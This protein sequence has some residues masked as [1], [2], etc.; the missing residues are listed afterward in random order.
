MIVHWSFVKVSHRFSH[1]PKLLFASLTF[2]YDESS[3]LVTAKFRWTYRLTD[4]INQEVL[5]SF[6]EEYTFTNSALQE[7]TPIALENNSK[8]ILY[9]F[10]KQFAVYTEKDSVMI[11]PTSFYEAEINYVLI[12][13]EIQGGK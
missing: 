4:T 8:A 13:E 12:S 1:Q 5:F 3:S 7:A 11:Q 10:Q 9:H 6:I 2:R